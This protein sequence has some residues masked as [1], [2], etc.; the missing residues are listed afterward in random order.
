MSMGLLALLDD[1]MALARVAAASLDDV[2]GQAAKAGSKAAGVVVDDAAVTPSYVTNLPAHRELPVIARITLGSLRNKLLIL[3]PAALAL[4]WAAPML[5]LP[6]LS[7]GGAYLCFEG[8][9]KILSL[10]MPHPPLSSSQDEAIPTL[11]AQAL[12]DEKVAS[13]IRTDFILSAE[14]MA[15]TLAALP[16]GSVWSRGIVLGLVGI[17]I[18]LGVYGVVALIVKA[19][20]LGLA[21]ARTSAQ[22]GLGR[23]TRAVG[24]GLVLGMPTFLSLLGGVGTLAMLWVGGGILLH[25]LE[26]IG[27]LS[28]PHFIH[29]MSAQGATLLPRMSGLVSWLLSALGAGL[30][31]LMIGS[32]LIVVLSGAKGISRMFSKKHTIRP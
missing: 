14:I 21:L 2:A 25:S 29:Q 5:I 32:G 8:S 13:A 19:D 17:G 28:L 16:D 9:E 24:R 18:T 26:T 6:L 27:F 11:S 1:V 7:L 22:H 31:G 23:L 30:A 20:D 12:E 10:V 3:L 4:S 15:I